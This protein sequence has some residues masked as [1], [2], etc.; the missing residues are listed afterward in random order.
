MDEEPSITQYTTRDWTTRKWRGY[1]QRQNRDHLLIVYPDANDS[2]GILVAFALDVWRHVLFEGM[3][4]TI[5]LRE[6]VIQSLSK[7]KD[8]VARSLIREIYYGS[9]V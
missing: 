9:L 7:D 2:F 4:L 3:T 1:G 8:Y 5:V 6:E